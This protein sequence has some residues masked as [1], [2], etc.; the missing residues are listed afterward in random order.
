MKQK[1][2]DEIEKLK[3]YLSEDINWM[4]GD[5]D[6]E[7]EILK[8]KLEGYELGKQ[9]TLKEFSERLKEAYDENMEEDFVIT[10]DKI[11]KELE[12]ESK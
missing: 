9:K 5:V 1:L 12:N 7:S 10:I 3:P 11:K 4:D 2:K 8:A 6:I